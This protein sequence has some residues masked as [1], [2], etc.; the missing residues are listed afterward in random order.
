MAANKTPLTEEEYWRIF[1]LIRG[2]VEAAIKS[3]HAYLTINKLMV[4]SAGSKR[5]INE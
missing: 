1:D 3:N 4:T 2:D 5:R